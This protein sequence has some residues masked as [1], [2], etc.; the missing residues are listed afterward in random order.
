MKAQQSIVH[1][2]DNLLRSQLTLAS[3]SGLNAAACVCRHWYTW[4]SST[5]FRK[6][7]RDMELRRM[8]NLRD[9]LREDIR[10]ARARLV[11]WRAANVV[12][13]ALGLQWT[14]EEAF[15]AGFYGQWEEQR[16]D[17]L[18]I[19][20]TTEDL[21]NAFGNMSALHWGAYS[22]SIEDIVFLHEEGADLSRCDDNQPRGVH[23][24][25]HGHVVHAA[26][27]N[28]MGAAIIQYACDQGV[29][30]PVVPSDN[31]G[32]SV[33]RN[34]LYNARSTPEE[35]LDILLLNGCRAERSWLQWVEAH[36][37]PH[38][39]PRRAREGVRILVPRTFAPPIGPLSARDE[40]GNR[41]LHILHVFCDAWVQHDG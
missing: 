33:L 11:S 9:K 36:T 31:N 18:R 4:T 29:P 41:L 13:R 12:Q 19:G 40:V 17:I 15:R 32:D 14:P 7:L 6:Q 5:A 28:K 27:K 23:D 26:A 30:L 25:T 24:P 34:Y 38:P 8:E 37:K 1:W 39:V 2:P 3:Y 22:G 20:P 16:L 21:H 10:E 35:I